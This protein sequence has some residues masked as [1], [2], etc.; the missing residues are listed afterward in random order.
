MLVSL[1]VQALI[2]VCANAS[3]RL[4]LPS[5]LSLQS[6][7]SI[8]V[9]AVSAALESMGTGLVIHKTDADCFVNIHPL[10]Y[11]ISFFFFHSLFFLSSIRR[12]RFFLSA[13][14]TQ[15]RINWSTNRVIMQ[16]LIVTLPCML[17]D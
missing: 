14:T 11:Q 17:H 12:T 7:S 8:C 5:V 15:L 13:I 4:P 6:E 9:A 3:V 2:A 1:P 10:K 16:L